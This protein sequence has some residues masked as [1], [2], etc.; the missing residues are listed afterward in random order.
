MP[1]T[2]LVRFTYAHVFEPKASENGLLKYSTG[3][4][5]PK[6][7]KKACDA[8]K[9]LVD[10]AVKKGIEKGKF[11][12]EASESRSF[13]YPLRDGDEY[14]ATAS[15]PEQKEARESYR[16]MLF[17][18]ASSDR[19]VGVV[20]KY[21]NP[22]MNQSDFYS[23]CWG[24]ADINLYAYNNKSLGV[25]VGLHN[26]MKKKD[27]DRLDGQRSAQAAFA[28]VTEDMADSADSDLV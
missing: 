14:Y 21:G 13:K 18:N 12:K 11:N 24:H 15:T 27:D 28:G 6:S 17:I 26:V 3:M 19:P 9:A 4:L 8:M 7:D 16:G 25:G 2:P 23:G 1:I 22:I 20:D 5:V 10:A